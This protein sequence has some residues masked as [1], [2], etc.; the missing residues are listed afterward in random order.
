MSTVLF[1]E[2]EDIVR[3]IAGNLFEINGHSFFGARDGQEAMELFNQHKSEINI[4]IS[5]LDMP[6]LNGDEL[7]YKVR[8]QNPDIPFYIV[9]AMDPYEKRIKTLLNDRLSGYYQKPVSLE[10]LLLLAK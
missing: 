1:A 6:I 5:D 10:K 3:K 8:K 2:D 9:S 4:I 7:F